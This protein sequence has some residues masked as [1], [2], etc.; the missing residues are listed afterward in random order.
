MEVF[1]EQLTGFNASYGTKSETA[2]TNQENLFIDASKN[3]LLA[4][5]VSE[6]KVNQLMKQGKDKMVKMAML[7][8]FENKKSINKENL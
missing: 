4:N 5:G 6:K 7:T 8:F 1:Q 2:K 3:L